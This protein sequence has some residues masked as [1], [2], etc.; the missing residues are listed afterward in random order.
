VALELLVQSDPSHSVLKQPRSG[1]P[2][3]SGLEHIPECFTSPLGSEMGQR[4]C[5]RQ[6][7]LSHINEEI[8]GSIWNAYGYFYVLGYQ[9]QCLNR[10]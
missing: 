9:E 6:N 4:P 1:L 8:V 3:K 7:N 5:S 10:V 2:A